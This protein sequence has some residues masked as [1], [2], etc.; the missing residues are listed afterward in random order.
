MTHTVDPSPKKLTPSPEIRKTVAGR[1][2]PAPVNWAWGVYDPHPF[3][4]LLFDPPNLLS[5]FR[6]SRFLH[7]RPLLG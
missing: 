6:K 5:Q 3:S 1:A 4:C 7:A 2:L